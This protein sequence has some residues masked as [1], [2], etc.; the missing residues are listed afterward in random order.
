MKKY[1]RRILAVGFCFLVIVAVN[2]ALP[3]MLPGNPVA[4]LTGMAEEDMTP[5]Q[6][7]YYTHALHLDEGI[8]SQ[9]WHYLVSL[10]DGTLGYSFKKDAVVSALIAERLGYT[11][12]LTTPGVI[13]ST[14]I[15]LAWGLRC[16]YHRGSPADRISTVGMI[17]LNAIPG[18]LLGLTLILL[19]CF[20]HRWLPYTG[21][22][23]PHVTA[24]TAAYWMD[25]VR[26]LFLPVLTLTL[27]TLPSRYLL[28]RN[29][30]EKIMDEKYVLYAKARGLSESKILRC[31]I[32]PNVAQPFITMVGMSVSVCVGGSVLVENIF[33]ID[34]MGKLLTE[35][36][37]T[38]D[39]PLMQGILFVTTGIMALSILVTDLLCAAID[40]RVRRRQ[41][42]AEEA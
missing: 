11:L 9:F 33:S 19:C 24:G 30:V 27:S 23:S 36:V 40:P 2:F 3:R 42:D 26:H 35:A 6:I 39:Y 15:G 17:V 7:Q 12:Q 32:L 29:T 5:V 13:L 18:F 41:A 38:L 16:G 28:M 4:Y 31:Y 25:R 22:N 34:G 14:L 20:E 1:G 8:F 37:Y 10:T 21:V